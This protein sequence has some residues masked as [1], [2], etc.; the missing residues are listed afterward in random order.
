MTTTP[1]TLE[2]DDIHKLLNFLKNDHGTP[3]QQIRCVRNYCMTVLM[4]EA[5]VRVGELVRLKVS[6]LWYADAPVSNLV[7]TSDVAKNQE[8][9]IIPVSEYLRD[10]INYLKES[11]WRDSVQFTSS[12]A[13]SIDTISN[14]ITTRQV[15]RIISNAGM[16][17][18]NR[19]VNPHMLRHTFATRL[20]RV[21]D[22]R[23]VQILLGHKHITSTQ[24]YTHPNGDDMR[25]A[26]DSVGDGSI[27]SG[28]DVLA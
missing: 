25:K 6:H 7:I 17:A 2:S 26:I 8:R 28:L 22:M 18:L 21:T 14:H 11:Y 4:L 9:R 20:M 12:W 10:T 27:G 16:K 24:I 3:T 13:I 19:P 5:G 1:Q 15:E 23:T